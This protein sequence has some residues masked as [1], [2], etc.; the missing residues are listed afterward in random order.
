MSFCTAG[1]DAKLGQERKLTKA[2]IHA[3]RFY[4]IEQRI[5]SETR[6]RD[7][8]CMKTMWKVM[9]IS[10]RVLLSQQVNGTV[11]HKLLGLVRER[12]RSQGPH[13]FRLSG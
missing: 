13:R 11:Q 2:L 10:G 6:V 1:G 4:G 3:Y 7:A 9:I 12:V 8:C 5:L